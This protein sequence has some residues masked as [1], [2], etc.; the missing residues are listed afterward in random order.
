M[1][2]LL[3]AMSF[4]F[5]DDDASKTDAAAEKLYAASQK[6][7][8]ESKTLKVEIDATFEGGGQ[9][10]TIKGT[11]LLST[12][13]KA[14]ALL[15]MKRGDRE[16]R[17]QMVCDGA[18]RWTKSGEKTRTVDV[19]KD[20][21]QRIQNGIVSFGPTMAMLIPASA[22]SSEP[23]VTDLSSG[24][25]ER[26]GKSETQ[27]LKYKLKQS[28]GDVLEVTAWIDVKTRLPIKRVISMGGEKGKITESTTFTLNPKLDKE[29]FKVPE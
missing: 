11:L 4:W 15:E 17:I 25:K 13:N 18:K 6:V 29:T 22:I 5:A 23:K 9:T 24:G 21:A 2:G 7:L 12:G 27:V 1:T 3:L 20:F 16:H 10:G 28:S 8:R 26:V 19:K 14:R